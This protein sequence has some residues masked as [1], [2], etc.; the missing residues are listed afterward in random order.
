MTEIQA[1]YLQ[2]ANLGKGPFNLK[3]GAV[4]TEARSSNSVVF[5]LQQDPIPLD[6][7]EQLPQECAS[8]RLGR[9]LHLRALPQL[10]QRP[11]GLR[12]GGLLL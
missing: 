12:L 6:P 2:M 8:F 7:G 4:A 5:S 1:S 11:R 10:L 3:Q 9:R